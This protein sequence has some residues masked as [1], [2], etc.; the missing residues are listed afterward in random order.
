MVPIKI[1]TH[2]VIKN[3]D[4]E[5]YLSARQKKQLKKMLDVIACHRIA[6][7]KKINNYVICNLDEPYANEVYL[8][9]LAGEDRKGNE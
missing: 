8:D 5:K 1:D 4:I 9:I 3:E 6:D 2:T 7:G